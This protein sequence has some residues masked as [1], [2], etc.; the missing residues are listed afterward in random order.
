MDMVDQ[1]IVHME[2]RVAIPQPLLPNIKVTVADL[3]LLKVHL[4]N[5]PTHH[6]Q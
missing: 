2:I 3:V 1:A 6:H 4:S 5:K